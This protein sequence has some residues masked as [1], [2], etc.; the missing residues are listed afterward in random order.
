MFDTGDRQRTLQKYFCCNS[1]LV[2]I[3]MLISLNLIY[4]VPAFK[5]VEP[6]FNQTFKALRFYIFFIEYFFY[7]DATCSSCMDT[8]SSELLSLS[9]L[10]HCCVNLMCCW[11]VLRYIFSFLSKNRAD[12]WSF[13]ITALQLAHGHAPFSKYPPMKVNLFILIFMWEDLPTWS[14]HG[15]L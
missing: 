12:I 9:S 5:I 13:G 8:T 15:G 4:D 10:F 2:Y 3:S 7:Q 6:L 14:F 1:L 11:S